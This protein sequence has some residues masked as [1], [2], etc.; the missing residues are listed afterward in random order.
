MTRRMLSPTRGIAIATLVVG[1]VAAGCGNSEPQMAPTQPSKRPVSIFARA[2]RTRKQVQRLAAEAEEPQKTKAQ[3]ATKLK[4]AEKL[5]IQAAGY[6][7]EVAQY[8]SE[9]AKSH[10]R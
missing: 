3:R 6:E 9:Y 7:R 1:L 5:A 8:E 10:K 2:N 4:Q